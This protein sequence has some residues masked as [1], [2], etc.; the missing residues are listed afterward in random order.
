MIDSCNNLPAPCYESGEKDI[1]TTYINLKKIMYK[2]NNDV[3]YEINI[4]D[5]YLFTEDFETFIKNVYKKE[6]K[7][8]YSLSDWFKYV[9][10]GIINKINRNLLMYYLSKN[11]LSHLHLMNSK[12]VNE[13][14][15]EIIFSPRPRRKIVIDNL[16]ILEKID[17]SEIEFIFCK[18]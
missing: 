6:Y 10:P 12:K 3:Y 16:N 14:P 8:G 13:D 9:S 1:I 4:S 5:D 11:N 18:F 17:L 2:I 15:N 7:S